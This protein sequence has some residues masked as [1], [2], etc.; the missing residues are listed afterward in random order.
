MPFAPPHAADD[1]E[2]RWLHGD[3]KD[4][5]YIYTHRIYNEFVTIGLLN[6]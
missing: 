3:L 5:A 6:E 2:N 4:V 1:P